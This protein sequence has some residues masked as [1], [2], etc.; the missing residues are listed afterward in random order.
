MSLFRQSKDVVESIGKMNL[1]KDLEESI[2]ILNKNPNVVGLQSLI[3]EIQLRIVDPDTDEREIVQIQL[4]VTRRKEDFIDKP[5]NEGQ[6]IEE[7]GEILNE[8]ESQIFEEGSVRTC[9]VC[10]C[11][12]TDCSQC[13]E[14]DGHPCWWI[15]DDLCSSCESEKEVKND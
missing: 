11:T 9:R 5:D 13:I 6:Q 12:D 1:Q 4:V 7:I 14:K 15:E 8:L 3:G 10:G 2:Y